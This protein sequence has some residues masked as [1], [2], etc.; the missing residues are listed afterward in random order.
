MLYKLHSYSVMCYKGIDVFVRD[1]SCNL[2]SATRKRPCV[3]R[4]KV[5]SGIFLYNENNITEGKPWFI[6]CL[7]SLYL[8]DKGCLSWPRTAHS[9]PYSALNFLLD[10]TWLI[11]LRSWE[12]R[13]ECRHV[14]FP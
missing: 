3:L 4:D 13:W 12:W 7:H 9:V 5:I 11:T 10:H 2:V 1:S 8:I 14:A 6:R